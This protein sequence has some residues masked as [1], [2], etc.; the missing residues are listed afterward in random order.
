MTCRD[1]QHYLDSFEANKPRAGLAGYGYCNAGETP[2]LRAMFFHQSRSI[3]QFLP[4]RF[5]ER[6]QP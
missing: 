5:K 1:C 3:C 2:Q 6:P 4:T